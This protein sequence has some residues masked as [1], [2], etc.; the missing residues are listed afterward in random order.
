MGGTHAY[1]SVT[2]L[3]ELA[4]KLAGLGHSRALVGVIQ[5]LTK[6]IDLL[7]DT[8]TTDTAL[9]A[10][11]LLCLDLKCFNELSAMS[12]WRRE[13]LDWMHKAGDVPAATDL[14]AYLEAV[15]LAFMDAQ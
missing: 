9:R 12:T 14:L 4:K 7:I 3:A 8:A 6:A 10:L 2:N 15:E 5:P 13:S 11:Q 1:H